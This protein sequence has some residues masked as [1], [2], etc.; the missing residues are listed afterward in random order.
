MSRKKPITPNSVIRSALRKLWLQ[1]RERY[2]VLK[3]G[4]CRKCGRGKVELERSG[5]A[6]EVH[7]IENIDW[8]PV[9]EAIRKQILV[10]PKKLSCLC[11]ECHGKETTLRR[12]DDENKSQ[13]RPRV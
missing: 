7:H 8:V 12:Y 4:K 10:D 13:T 5:I 11:L 9:F 2:A 6:L 3:I 1:S